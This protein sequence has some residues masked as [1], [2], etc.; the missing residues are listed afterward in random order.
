MAAEEHRIEYRD[1]VLSVPRVAGM[2]LF[3]VYE[4][5]GAL[6]LVASTMEDINP[7]PGDYIVRR[8]WATATAPTLYRVVEG[9][10]R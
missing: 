8:A 5:S 10:H 7:E 2:V 3:E 4:A 9:D 6:L 1:K